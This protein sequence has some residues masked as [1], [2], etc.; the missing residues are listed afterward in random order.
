M[1]D[2][3][4][5]FFYFLIIVLFLIMFAYLLKEMFGK[6]K[7]QRELA[8]LRR[9]ALWHTL[10]GLGCRAF[11]PTNSLSWARRESYKLLGSYP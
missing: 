9:V 2:A 3:T 10:W 1:N 11:N 7:D 6:K 4:F 8:T 5:Y